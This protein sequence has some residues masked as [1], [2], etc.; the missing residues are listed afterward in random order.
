MFLVGVFLDDSEPQDPAPVRLDFS[1]TVLTDPSNNRYGEHFLELRPALRQ[2]FFIGDG[3]TETGQG[4]RQIFHVPDEA[5]RLFLGF[6]DSYNFGLVGCN[7]PPGGCTPAPND[8]SLAGFYLDNS[9]ELTVTLLDVIDCNNNQVPDNLDIVRG[10]SNDC[11]SDGIPEECQTDCN[12][13]RLDDS[14]DIRDG[15]SR[16]MRAG[17]R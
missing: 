8:T 1:A 9:G 2:I 10:T 7:C 6:A 5:T 3:L 13:N 14:C 15:R 17:M 16:R 11:Q 4:G 12:G